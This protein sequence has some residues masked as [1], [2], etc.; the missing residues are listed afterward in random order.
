MSS[1][2]KKMDRGWRAT[3]WVY[4]LNLR[5][6]ENHKKRC[7]CSSYEGVKAVQPLLRVLYPILLAGF[8]A[9][10]QA[11]WMIC[12]DREAKTCSWG[13]CHLPLSPYR[14]VPFPPPLCLHSYSLPSGNSVLMLWAQYRT[15]LPGQFQLQTTALVLTFLHIT[16]LIF[17]T[18]SPPWHCWWQLHIF[19]T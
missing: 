2:L 11:A 19:A 7:P 8:P 15:P 17:T 18:F 16:F 6:E 12:K 5:R 1:L 3:T 4:Y 13:L 9:L 14:F 10:V